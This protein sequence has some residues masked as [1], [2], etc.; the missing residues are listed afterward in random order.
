MF[1]IGAITVTKHKSYNQVK[2]Y[3]ANQVLLSEDKYLPSVRHLAQVIGASKS[4]V[5]KVLITLHEVDRWLDRYQDGNSP[6]NTIYKII[7]TAT[8]CDDF[9][10]YIL[11]PHRKQIKFR[12]MFK[13]GGQSYKSGQSFKWFFGDTE[14]DNAV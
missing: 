1:K 4:A 13:N 12:K 14:V 5:S 11:M 2:H 6:R 7:A 8:Q 10:S 3:I 9:K